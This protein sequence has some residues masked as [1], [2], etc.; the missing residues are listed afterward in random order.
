MLFL[1]FGVLV[2]GAG[3]ISEGGR[4]WNKYP[5]PIANDPQRAY[6]WKRS[7]FMCALFPSLVEKTENRSRAEQEKRL[8]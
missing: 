5:A 7:Q 6:D 4:E 1:S 8:R 3:A 2:N